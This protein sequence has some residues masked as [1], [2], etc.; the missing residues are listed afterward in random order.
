MVSRLDQWTLDVRDVASMARFWAA[1]LGYRVGDDG[2]H[3]W[4]PPEAGPHAPSVWLQPVDEPTPGKN[5]G[6]PDLVPADGDVDAEVARL[7]ALGARHVDV[8]QSGDEGFVVL[9]DPEGNEFC[10]LRR[11]RPDG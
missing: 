1:V 11:R 8:G 4:P 2:Q 9:A 10:V 3:L 5:R 7:L 6:H